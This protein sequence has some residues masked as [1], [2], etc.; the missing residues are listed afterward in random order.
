MLSFAVKVDSPS[1]SR[2]R[3]LAAISKAADTEQETI[4][5]LGR[6]AMAAKNQP[7]AEYLA[8]ATQSVFLSLC[9]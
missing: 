2:L 3:A 6:A 9:H 7:E 4:R 1:P 8:A 5:E